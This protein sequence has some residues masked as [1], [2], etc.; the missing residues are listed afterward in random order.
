MKKL[1]KSSQVK[2]IKYLFG[3]GLP[4]GVRNSQIL[5]TMTVG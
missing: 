5:S 3:G 4:L 1:Q 2:F